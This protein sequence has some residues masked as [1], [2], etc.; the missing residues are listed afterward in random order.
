MANVCKYTLEEDQ[1]I[2]DYICIN[3]LH[4]HWRGNEMWNILE[5]TGIFGPRTSQSMKERFRKKIYPVLRMRT[6][7]NCSDDDIRKFDEGEVEV[8]QGKRR[9]MSREKSFQLKQV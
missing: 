4:A 7:Y 3:D 9:P 6:V 5:K 2:L 1:Q 8:A